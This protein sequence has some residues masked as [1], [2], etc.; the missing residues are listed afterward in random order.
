MLQGLTDAGYINYSKVLNSKNYGIPQNRERIFV[1]SIRKDIYEQGQRFEFPKE[2]PLRFDESIFD[3]K[4]IWIN[5]KTINH[6]NIEVPKGRY[7]AD[8]RYDDGLR[9]RKDLIWPCLT[10]KTSTSISGT[11]LLIKDGKIGYITTEERFLIQGFEK[12]DYKNAYNALKR[13]RNSIAKIKIELDKQSG[14]T[15]TVNVEEELIENLIYE[16][17]QETQISWL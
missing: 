3:N 10:T 8:F 17:K 12:V 5:D 6:M 1:V 2:I 9:I 16:R 11:P 14:N 15:I 7:L 13:A 4:R